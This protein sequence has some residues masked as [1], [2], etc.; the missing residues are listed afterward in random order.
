MGAAGRSAGRRKSRNTRVPD[1]NLDVVGNGASELGDDTARIA[2]GARTGR[3][4]NDATGI[5]HRVVPNRLGDPVEF[6][7]A[8]TVTHDRIKAV[9]QLI[10]MLRYGLRSRQPCF[11][12]RYEEEQALGLWAHLGRIP[13]CN[14][15]ESRT[16]R[17]ITRAAALRQ[18]RH[19]RS[20]NLTLS[21]PRPTLSREKQE[22]LSG[23]ARLRH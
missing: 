13:I 16:P 17:R 23:R 9:A 19:C 10:L 5:V 11:R 4:A 7:A 3:A 21:W 2:N 6:T 20:P 8:S 18:N 14:S 15:S 12:S 22:R 1:T